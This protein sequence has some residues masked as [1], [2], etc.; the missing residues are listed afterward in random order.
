M[1]D[2][3]LSKTIID[4]ISKEINNLNELLN[5]LKD[6]ISEKSSMEFVLERAN[7]IIKNLNTYMPKDVYVGSWVRGEGVG[8]YV[9]N[10][11]EHGVVCRLFEVYD[12]D[13]DDLRVKAYLCMQYAKDPQYVKALKH[14]FGF[15]GEV[16]VPQE[17]TLIDALILLNDNL[18]RKVQSLQQKESKRSSNIKVSIT[19]NS[20]SGDNSTTS[21]ESTDDNGDTIVYAYVEPVKRGNITF[22]QWYVTAEG[23]KIGL[24]TSP[25]L[26]ASPKLASN[27]AYDTTLSRLMI[28]EKLRDSAN[29]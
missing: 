28:L 14:S 2:K 7:S 3:E 12:H 13:D 1:S 17:S 24:S 21:I 4:S 11:I 23:T 29:T 5:L 26:Y 9:L 25:E 22:W 16:Y 8:M 10:I 20:R 19:L 6:S 18:G 15:Q 27:V